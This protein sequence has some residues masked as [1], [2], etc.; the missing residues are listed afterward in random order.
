MT[1]VSSIAHHILVAMP[2]GVRDPE[3]EKSVIYLC[4]HHDMGSVGLIIN[5]P[6]QF[7]LG[8]VFEQLHIQPLHKEENFQPL[9]F[10]GP[11]QAERGFVMHKEGHW[12][13][14]LM[15]QKDEV[16]ITTSNDI[17][18][19]IAEEKGPYPKD[20]DRLVILGYM[21][22]M[23][24]QLEQEIANNAWLVCPYRA[25]LVYEVPFAQRWEEAGKS[26][27]VN[28]QHLINSIGHA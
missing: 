14:S 17:I 18:R 20:K 10:G 22:W 8:L 2:Q 3:L 16:T 27:G 15:L 21:G 28:M 1:N 26:I 23:E 9:L 25:E 11:L 13:S 7:S 19:A 12:R 4:E 5:K 24:H 6:M